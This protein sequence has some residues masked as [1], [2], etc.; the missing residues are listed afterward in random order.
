MFAVIAKFVN[1]SAI[2]DGSLVLGFGAEDHAVFLVLLLAVF[3]DGQSLPMAAS[4]KKMVGAPF[5]A[6]NLEVGPAL[7]LP[8][9]YEVDWDVLARECKR[10]CGSIGQPREVVLEMALKARS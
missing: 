4:V 9:D 5:D 8:D 6:D 2:L 7:G 10:F 1:A 3:P